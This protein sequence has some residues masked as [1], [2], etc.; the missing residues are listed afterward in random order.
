MVSEF[1]FLIMLTWDYHLY[2]EGEKINNICITPF[3]C[4]DLKYNIFSLERK[5][6]K[7]T[8]DLE[9]IDIK[10]N[11]SLLFWVNVFILCGCSNF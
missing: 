7:N 4:N 9:P 3:I 1:C 10:I 11:I 5:I 6:L 2:R 8:E